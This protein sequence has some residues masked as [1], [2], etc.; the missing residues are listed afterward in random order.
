MAS[1]KDKHVLHKM[2]KEIKNMYDGHIICLRVFKM[3][4]KNFW[5]EEDH[6]VLEH[7]FTGME[8]TATHFDITFTPWHL[9]L[10]KGEL[11]MVLKLFWNSNPEQCQYEA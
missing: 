8:Q 10:R 9:E 4:N 7:S 6:K 5:R 1:L 3:K 2:E 11:P